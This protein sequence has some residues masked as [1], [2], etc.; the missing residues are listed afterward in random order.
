MRMVSITR[1]VPSK[2]RK[3]IEA[4]AWEF[5]DDILLWARTNRCQ[6]RCQVSVQ[7]AR[8]IVNAILKFWLV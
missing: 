4:N 7:M 5:N 6:R 3:T 2:G 8:T 1:N